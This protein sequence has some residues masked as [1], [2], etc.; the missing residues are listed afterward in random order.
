MGLEFKVDVQLDANKIEKKVNS[1]FDETLMLQIHSLFERYCDPY[2]PY[3]H[4][5]LSRTTDVTA[6]RVRYTQP[7]AHYQYVGEDF[8]HTLEVHPKAT[9]YWDKVMMSEMGEQ[10]CD[11]VYELIHRR[12]KE[13]YG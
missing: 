11:E 5:P 12:A 13:L 10:F 2:V 1:L 8:N 6:E 9:A 3:L 4:G 7:Y